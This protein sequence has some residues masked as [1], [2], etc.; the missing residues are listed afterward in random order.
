ME[1]TEGKIL[2]IAGT[3]GDEGFSRD[4]FRNLASRYPRNEYGYDRTVGNP[5]ALRKGVRYTEVDLNR[6]AP[7]NPESNLYEE[8]RAAQIVE[9]SKN[10]EFA[11]DVHGSVAD[12]GIVTIIPYPT[13]PNL[14]LASMLPIERNVIWYSKSSLEK[15]PLVQFTDCPGVEIE[16][17][18]KSSG[19][20]Q[21]DL[22]EVLSK[23]L[24]SRANSNLDDLIQKFKG[25][26]FFNVYGR[27]DGDGSPYRD[28]VLSQN[29]DEEFYP[30]M[31]NQYPGIAC[32]KMKRVSLENLF[33]I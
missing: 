18:P 4:V 20:I 6:S 26:E 29:E 32:Y 5:R 31:S 16:C 33:L 17:G 15:G 7:G 1:R 10:Y 27:L 30:F 28:F 22:E 13:L 24:E 14:A 8:R 25:K 19:Q 2:F 11:I 23:F 9:Q 21:I 12:C 3:H